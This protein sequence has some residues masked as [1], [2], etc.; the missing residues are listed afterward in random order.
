M[1]KVLLA[2]P[3][4][5]D[6]GGI[7]RWT[8][9]I[10]SYYQQHKDDVDLD[11][12]ST[13]RKDVGRLLTN[14]FMRIQKGIS[15][16][17][18]ILKEQSRMMKKKQYDVMHMTSSASFGLFKDYLMLKKARKKNVRTIIHFRF[19]RIPELYKINNWEWKMLKRV[20]ELSD[21]V[22]V[23][24]EKSYASLHT[25]GF[26]NVLKLPNPISPR[27]LALIEKS[28]LR[29]R[30]ARTVLFVGHCYWDKGIKELIMACKEIPNIKVIMM[31]GIE[32]EVADY[33]RNLSNN[34]DWLDI[35]GE[36]SYEEVIIAMMSCGV[37]V[38]PTYT[39]GFPNVI[40]ES[41]ACGCPIVTTDVGAIPEMLDIENGM[42]CGVCVKPRDV[43]ML[44][45][46]ILKM[47]EDVEYA[48]R[49]GDSA[50]QRVNS[51]Y[52]MPKVWNDLVDIWNNS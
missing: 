33:L 2:A 19:G 25:A 3:F 30:K 35:K 21:K 44:K 47:L 5:K 37:F 41:M 28:D 20:V 8:E 34:E 22:I 32:E 39:E 18:Y 14:K 17:L 51:L 9:H 26:N 50:R 31:G 45:K 13:G 23:L 36:S 16:Y 38:L 24:D 49:C 52:S 15:A 4:G 40:L 11:L 7:A 1:V 27:V 42:N 10:L 48:R 43:E 46:G 12:L 6:T 29:E